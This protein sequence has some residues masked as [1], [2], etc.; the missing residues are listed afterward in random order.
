M[1]VI[2]HLW[3]QLNHTPLPQAGPIGYIVLAL[4][5]GLEGPFATLAGGALAGSGRMLPQVVVLTAI[6]AN[7]VADVFWYTLGYTGKAEWLLPYAR[8]FGIRP[9]HVSQLQTSMYHNAYRLLPLTKFGAGLAIPALIATGMARAPWRRWLPTLAVAEALRSFLLV[10]IGYSAA[11][12][13]T[14][15]STGIRVVMAA[16]TVSLGIAF[17]LWLRR[18]RRPLPALEEVRHDPLSL[19]E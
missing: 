17:V 4:L 5:V 18:C 15:A 16:V 8:W 13:L 1:D 14:Q 3:M 2:Q 6:T 11:S 7:L 9:H 10:T 12:A 19:P